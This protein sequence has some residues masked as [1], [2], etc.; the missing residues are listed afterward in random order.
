MFARFKKPL[1]IFLAVAFFIGAT[2]VA[3]GYLHSG[4]EKPATEKQVLY[5]M[6]Q[7]QVDAA[8][9]DVLEGLFTGK[10][11]ETITTTEI[12]ASFGF[13][14][15]DIVYHDGRYMAYYIT[16]RTTTGKGG[17]GLAVSDDGM[18][19][20][21]GGCVI[22]PGED[23]DCNGTYFAGVWVDDD[24]TFYLAYECKGGADTEYGTLENVALAVSDNGVDWTKKGI[25]LY[26][27][28][29]VW[30][31]KANVGTPELYKVGDMWYL[32]FHGFDYT[33]CRVGVAYGKSLYDLTVVS[34]P[35]LT[36][37]DN[38]LW[39]GTIGRRDVIYCN[40]YYYMVYEIST[41]QST[42]GFASSQ[43]THM[44]ARSKDLVHWETT[45]GPQLTQRRSGFGYD[46]P[47]WMVVNN[48]LY[49]YMREGHSTTAV[50]LTVAN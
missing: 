38:A 2:W 39:S 14:F 40:G 43:W 29:N 22:Q 41:D 6:T 4:T 48:E 8:F 49:V 12:G 36:T 13:H 18:N 30:W 23:Y 47:C 44:F 31:Q 1:L 28:H 42:G 45:S 9:S 17:V 11:T 26:A 24:G 16:Y 37:Q 3:A 33:D 25:I 34:E 46:G 35:I 20:T 15:P 32:F 10:T 5:G 27:D 7:S 50:K 19:W 21:D